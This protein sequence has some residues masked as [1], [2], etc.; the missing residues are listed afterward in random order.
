[1]GL[2]IRIR[3]ASVPFVDPGLFRNKSYTLRLIVMFIVSGIGFSAFLSPL[4]LSEVQ[5]LARV[6]WFCHGTGRNRVG[7]AG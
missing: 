3:T 5:A 2:I 7:L 4:L 1:M 6:G